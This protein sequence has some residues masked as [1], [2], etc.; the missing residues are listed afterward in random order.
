MF[1]RKE[2][3]RRKI[4]ENKISLILS[5]NL[6]ERAESNADANEG[7]ILEISSTYL[8]KLLSK[9]DTVFKLNTLERN[10]LCVEKLYVKCLNLSPSQ[11]KCGSLLKKWSLIPGRETT[12]PRDIKCEGLN[13]AENE[14]KEPEVVITKNEG[15]EKPTEKYRRLEKRI[16]SR[17]ISPD[18]FE[19][20]N[21][22]IIERGENKESELLSA[23]TTDKEDGGQDCIDFVGE[24]ESFLF[25]QTDLQDSS[26]SAQ[27]F[28]ENQQEKNIS[29][30]NHVH[31]MSA[32]NGILHYESFY[33]ESEVLS[34]EYVDLTQ[35]SDDEGAQAALDIISATNDHGNG[36][37]GIQRQQLENEGKNT[38]QHNCTF[39]V[40]SEETFNGESMNVTDYIYRILSQDGSEDVCASDDEV[41]SFTR[42]NSADKNQRN[43]KT[44]CLKHSTCTCNCSSYESVCIS[45]EELNY[46]IVEPAVEREIDD[47]DKGDW[48]EEDEHAVTEQMQ[49]LSSASAKV[50]SKRNITEHSSFTSSGGKRAT[51]PKTSFIVR[52]TNVTPMP[53]FDGMKSPE[54]VRELGTFGVKAMKRKRGV[55]LLKHIYNAT[56]PFADSQRQQEDPEEQENLKKRRINANDPIGIVGDALMQK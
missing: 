42:N 14:C 1:I 40:A 5:E 46:S 53:D 16:K 32:E 43:R 36:I 9:D 10:E 15:L 6:V 47:W 18:L 23:Q 51:T 30:N 33:K 52:T 48:E 38:P 11:A 44:T 56:H 7:N 50:E 31:Q 37:A 54:V 26:G 8:E 2:E 41:S 12:P 27:L 49:D 21:E 25:T 3:E 29:S 17:S 39:I 4:I 24:N 19:S 13:E 22:S 20:D 45:N 34:Q 55:E 28:S 35:S